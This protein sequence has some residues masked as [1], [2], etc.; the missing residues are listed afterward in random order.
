M[1]KSWSPNQS[2]K[3]P[4]VPPALE[5]GAEPARLQHPQHLPVNRLEPPPVALGVVGRFLLAVVDLADAEAGVGDD[6]MERVVLDPGQNLAAVGADDLVL[7]QRVP[8][9]LD[10]LY[11]FVRGGLLVAQQLELLV[12]AMD[13]PRLGVQFFNKL[14]ELALADGPDLFQVTARRRRSTQPPCPWCRP[15]AGNFPGFRQEV[16]PPAS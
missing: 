3:W 15:Y 5:D 6:R 7:L 9:D 8:A 14:R 2:Q 12:A 13:R 10:R 4:H 1:M 16:F 11:L